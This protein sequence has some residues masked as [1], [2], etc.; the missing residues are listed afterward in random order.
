MKD[1]NYFLI[2]RRSV[3]ADTFIASGLALALFSM[4]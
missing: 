1:E 2:R 4:V 3:F